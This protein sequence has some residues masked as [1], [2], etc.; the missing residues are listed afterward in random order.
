MILPLKEYEKRKIKYNSLLKKQ[1]KFGHNIT[2]LRLAVFILGLITLIIMY[3]FKKY[4]LFDSIVA[5]V[6]VLLFYLAYI[7][8]NISDKEQYIAS[9]YAVNENSIKL[10]NGEWKKFK[11]NG[12]DF[13]DI[14]HNYSYDIDVFGDNSLFQ[15]MNTAHTYMGR[16]RLKKILTEKPGN[17][18][19]I[20]DRQSAIMELEPKIY[21]RQRLEAEGKIIHNK[22]QNPKEL[23]SWIE[24][25]QDFILKKQEIWVLRILSIVTAITSLTLTI[26]IINYL[27]NIFWNTDRSLPKMFQ[28]IPYYIPIFLISIQ[29]IILRVK[30]KDRVKNLAT[31]EKYNYNIKIYKNMLGHIEKYKFKSKYILNL[32]KELYNNECIS[33]SGQLENFS[34][35]CSSVA[36]RRNMLYSILNP[37]LMLEYHWN[38]SVETWKIKSG[39]NFEKWIDVIGEMEA[40]SSISTIKYNNPSWIMPEII[41]GSSRITAENMGHPL[42]GEKRVC[43][44]LNMGESHPVMLITGSNMSGKSTFMRTVGI[45]IILA[46]AGAPV[47][48]EQFCCTIIDLY[49]CMQISDNLTNNISSFYAEI[50]KIK[51]IVKASEEGKNVLFLLDEIFKGTNSIDRHTGAIILINQLSRNGNLGIISTHDLELGKMIDHKNSKVKNYHFSEYYRK[52]KIY[53]DYKLKH[54]ISSTRNA[55]YLMK[56]AGIEIN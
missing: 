22:E 50:L 52:N 55:V 29:C 32:Y 7:H 23:F 16:L 27:L 47:C 34:K 10:L 14:H 11:D 12:E 26:R 15:W 54:G 6:I 44:S 46:Y 30:R 13:I 40:L 38:I 45:N 2:N 20:C 56:L 3:I 5:G 51:N 18:H 24:E 21:F 19:S 39:K 43:N 28:A 4:I 31:A 17:E 25:S 9:L 53:F 37:I 42:L 8:K 35:I 49:T 36:N 41:T 1:Q 33:A 48:A